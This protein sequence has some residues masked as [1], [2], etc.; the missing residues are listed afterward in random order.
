MSDGSQSDSAAVT[1]FGHTVPPFAEVFPKVFRLCVDAMSMD[2]VKQ[3][4][5]AM[6]EGHRNA[7]GDYLGQ[8]G[9]AAVAEGVDPA[10][11]EVVSAGYSRPGSTG[12]DAFARAY[13][14]VMVRI[15]NAMSREQLA[16]VLS[17]LTSEDIASQSLFLGNAGREHVFSKL[18]TDAVQAILDR[19]ED[20][21]LLESGK[22][23]LN[24]I[25]AYSC[26]L[27]KEERV[28]GKLQKP[29]TIELKLRHSPKAIYM[30]WLAGPFKGRELMYN[31]ALI[32]TDKL[33]VREGGVL[34]IVPVTIGID[35]AVARRGTKH[36]V[37][38]VGIGHLLTLIEHDYVRAA[39]KGH[40]KRINMGIVDLDGRKTYKVES[41][42]PR[43][44][45]HGYYCY[46]MIH[47]TDFV[48][49]LE[50]RSEVFNFDDELDESYYYKDI[51]TSP[52]LTDAD[53]DPKNKKY[54]L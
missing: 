27:I 17:G 8:E 33:R 26:T 34:G 29:E 28:S 7:L 30:K 35:S 10:K 13:P 37:S 2:Q 22:L 21:V 51:T 6:P 49:G 9:I 14:E 20:W 32:G 15:H 50:I 53:F 23:A 19:T 39:P 3:A 5:S 52:A 54:H 40:I 38:E 48:R 42:L 11:V 16:K 1:C 18:R 25:P 4:V 36:L 41:V 24:A 45:S 46:R 31:E 43:D 12:P 47:Y 44:R